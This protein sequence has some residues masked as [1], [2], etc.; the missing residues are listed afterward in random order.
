MKLF[1]TA[2]KQ[3]RQLVVCVAQRR[4]STAGASSDTIPVRDVALVVSSRQELVE[5]LGSQVQVRTAFISEEEEQALLL[6]LEPGL[7]KKRYEFDHWD[8]V[9]AARVLG[10]AALI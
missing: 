7:R 2:A 10:F 5:R 4:C 8:D 1:L 9:G 6:E 3:L